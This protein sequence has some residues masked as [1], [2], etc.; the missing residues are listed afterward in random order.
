L[1]A[2]IGNFPPLSSALKRCGQNQ[3]AN[4]VAR[5]RNQLRPRLRDNQPSIW[6]MQLLLL[7]LQGGQS[8]AMFLE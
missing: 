4:P 5:K 3:I 8:A 6:V 7:A 2:T 1:S